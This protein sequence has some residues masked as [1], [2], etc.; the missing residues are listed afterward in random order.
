VLILDPDEFYTKGD[1]GRLKQILSSASG[2]AY[3]SAMHT[4]W[5]NGY[6]IDPPEKH[7]PCVAVRS[8]SR[9]RFTHSRG[10]NASLLRL[11]NDLILH[12]FSWV[13]TDYEVLRKISH[14][15]HSREFDT[16]RWYEDKWI[17]WMPGSKDFHPITPGQYHD[18]VK[19]EVPDDLKE[20]Y[21]SLCESLKQ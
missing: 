17:K 9:A 14:Y 19:A 10:T 5:K 11:P 2:T 15:G 8:G 12:H 4:Y 16:R 7:R 3:A 13:R 18:T 21:E 20:V 1:F 6:R